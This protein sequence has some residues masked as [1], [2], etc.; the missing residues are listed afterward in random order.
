MM[1]IEKLKLKPTE[2]KDLFFN[3]HFA[4]ISEYKWLMD[5]ANKVANRFELQKFKVP[6]FIF[7]NPNMHL[8]LNTLVKDQKHSVMIDGRYKKARVYMFETP[9]LFIAANCETGDRG[10]SWH[11]ASKEHIKTQN[12]P[13]YHHNDEVHL[14]S[15]EA[16]KEL[17]NFLQL[18][19]WHF[20]KNGALNKRESAEFAGYIEKVEKQFG[21]FPISNQ[22][23]NNKDP[24]GKN[25][26]DKKN[27][28][29][30]DEKSDHQQ[31]E[32]SKS[33]FSFFRFGK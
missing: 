25:T 32:Q 16:I 29:I 28:D 6:H 11:F 3:G 1:K 31:E 23:N 10:S 21:A 15:S 26:I 27:T 17:S 4:E 7:F 22:A 18:M 13:E 8:L 33:K 24:A 14:L 9:N 20:I 12:P 5:G 19:S 2:A 30:S